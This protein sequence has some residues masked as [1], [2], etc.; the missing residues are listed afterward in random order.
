[1][2]NAK[3][4]LIHVGYVKTGSTWLQTQIFNNKN[5]G[6]ALVCDRPLLTHQIIHPPIF[7]FNVDVIQQHINENLR[8]IN[9]E[10]VPVV[11]HERLAGSAISGGFDSTIIADRL[12][13]LLP[14][15][16]ALIVIREQ[17]SHILST[18]KE[19]VNQGGVCSLQQFLFP[20]EGRALPLFNFSFYEYHKLIEYYHSRWGREKILVLPYELLVQ[21]PLDFYNTIAS[22]VGAKNAPSIPSDRVRISKGSF[23]VSVERQ[24]NRLFYRSNVN[25]SAPFKISKMKGIVRVMNR[26]TPNWLNR[27]IKIDIQKQIPLD[28]MKRYA[29]SNKITESYSNFQLSDFGYYF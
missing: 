8:H 10:K 27:L 16:K 4:V 1:M 18:Y 19:Y 17:L 11:S 24:M 28:V 15:A 26:V 14:E 13:E 21:K 12:F 5:L 25:P 20:P 6:F 2:G 29:S 7:E 9:D 22:F 23:S 3:R